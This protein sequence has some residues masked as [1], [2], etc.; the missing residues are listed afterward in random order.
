MPCGARSWKTE[1]P[2]GPED[3]AAPKPRSDGAIWH[4]D[5]RAAARRARQ[6]A[7]VIAFSLAKERNDAAP[8][9]VMP[10]IS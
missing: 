5:G 10:S 3:P 8:A 1:A 4:E 7:S 2:P 9:T 6:K